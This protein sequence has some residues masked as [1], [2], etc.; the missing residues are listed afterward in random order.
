[1]IIQG[2]SDLVKVHLCL[3][4][5]KVYTEGANQTGHEVRAIYVTRLEFPLLRKAQEFA[6]Q[7]WFDRLRVH[8][9]QAN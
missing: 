3:A 6:K 4:H 8:C 9:K 2:H 1:M 7:N 5:E